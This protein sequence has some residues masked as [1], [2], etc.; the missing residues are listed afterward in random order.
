VVF[1]TLEDEWGLINVLV[2]PAVYQR[3]HTVFR[4]SPLI[5]VAGRLER[6]CGLVTIIAARLYALDLLPPADAPAPAG[7]AAGPG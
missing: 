2:P 5:A 1:L 6:R 3:D 4:Q 7:R